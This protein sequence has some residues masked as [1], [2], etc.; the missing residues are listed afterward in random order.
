MLDVKYYL[1][2]IDKKKGGITAYFNLFNF[3]PTTIFIFSF[4]RPDKY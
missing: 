2:I 3:L 4:W 1:T